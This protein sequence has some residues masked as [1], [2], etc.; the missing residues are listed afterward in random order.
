MSCRR[1][2]G[3]HR[4][5]YRPSGTSQRSSSRESPQAQWPAG[6]GL[7]GLLLAAAR[8]ARPG[9]PATAERLPLCDTTRPPTHA[10]PIAGVTT[11]TTLVADLPAEWTWTRLAAAALAAILT[12]PVQAKAQTTIWSSTLTIRDHR[13][14]PLAGLARPP[15]A[16]R[17]AWPRPEPAAFIRWRR[18]SGAMRSSSS[19]CSPWRAA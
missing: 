13:D 7:L 14:P 4:I 6:I 15:P 11:I 9:D 12:L 5:L 1:P 19:I 16:N 2:K 17:P 3:R 10:G 18:S 8:L